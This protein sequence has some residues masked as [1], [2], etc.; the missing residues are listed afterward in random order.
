M[1]PLTRDELIPLI[2]KIDLFSPLGR[3]EMAALAPAFFRRDVRR[4]EEIFD[5]DDPSTELFLILSGRVR[6][7]R[8]GEDGKEATLAIL[9]QGDF[10]GEISIFTGE[11]RSAAARAAEETELLVLEREH[12]L[13]A[14]NASP[15]IGLAIIEE[16][17]QRLLEADRTIASLLWDN[18][19]RKIILTLK[20]LAQTEGVAR[21]DA[22]VVK[23]R[24]THQEVADM[25][26]T[27][28][29]TASRILAFLKKSGAV[30]P[31]GRN[32]IIRETAIPPAFE[33]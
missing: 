1:K 9:Q 8:K 2:R 18:A 13:K 10:F 6:I 7:V 19:Y 29:E 26:G 14:I 17:S 33:P 20:R 3:D 32:V 23:R 4:G 5:Q 11:P 28:R 30:V 22:T 12:F 24:V 15:H 16:L 27:S 21:G 25:A 31:S